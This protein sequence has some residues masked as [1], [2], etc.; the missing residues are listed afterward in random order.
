MYWRLASIIACLWWNSRLT[1]KSYSKK[2]L[3]VTRTMHSPPT[4][5]MVGFRVLYVSKNEALGYNVKV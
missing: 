2:R 5:A 4:R 3:E 1:K